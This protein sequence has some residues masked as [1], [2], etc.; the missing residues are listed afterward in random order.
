ML[1]RDYQWPHCTEP[2]CD[3]VRTWSSVEMAQLAEARFTEVI[4]SWVDHVTGNTACACHVNPETR[5]RFPCDEYAARGEGR[6][7]A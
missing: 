7:R 3:H 5:A 6:R 1:S 2:G 4:D